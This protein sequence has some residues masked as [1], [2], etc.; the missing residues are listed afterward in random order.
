MPSNL[1]T[2]PNQT[3]K[4][5]LTL[6]GGGILGLLEAEVLMEMERQLA[7]LTGEDRPLCEHFDLIGGTSTGAIMA[8]GLALGFRAA[9][10]KDFYLEFGKDI[11]H[12][13]FIIEQFWHKY[14]DAPLAKALKAKFGETTTLGDDKLKTLLMV[15][16]KNATR[17]ATWFFSNIPGGSFYDLNKNLPLWQVVR[18]STAAPT[19]FPPQTITVT[20][21]KGQTSDDEFVD[22]GVSSYNNPSLQLFLEATDPDYHLGWKP[23]PDNLLLMSLGTGFSVQKIPAG[24]AA[25]YNDLQWAGYA[26]SEL[27]GDANLQQNVLM[28]L[29]G[30]R[31][32]AAPAGAAGVGAATGTPKPDAIAALSAT[33]G[34]NKL[35]TYQRITVSLTQERFD[36]LAKYDPRMKNIEPDSV[37]EMDCVDQMENLLIIGG[38]MAKEQVHMDALARFFPRRK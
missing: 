20:D 1:R 32:I 7:T 30:E 26:V 4:R 21:D 5:L 24:K 12:K 18:A 23:G 8:A 34:G 36:D 16:T 35:L 6:D 11:F 17:G 15:V 3:P 38:A 27:M 22:G 37:N 2:D 19:Y 28:H 13:V 29:I 33:V 9:Q 31:P 25:H 10:L 14:S